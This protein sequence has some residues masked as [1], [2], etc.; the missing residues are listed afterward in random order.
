MRSVRPPPALLGESDLSLSSAQSYEWTGKVLQSLR[1]SLLEHDFLEILPAILSSQD[2]P[3][4]RH[5]VAV[6]GDRARPE[7]RARDGRVSVDG[8]WAYHLAVSH[9]VEKQMALEHAE[10][11]YCVTPCLRLLMEGEELSGKH[12][13]TFFQLVVEWRAA[14]A[15]EVFAVTESLLG[16]F[17]RHLEPVLP[18]GEG[19]GEAAARLAGLRS[20]PYPR[21]TFAEALELAGRKPHEPQNTDLT[22]DEE[23]IL[24]ENFSSPF[25]I[26]RY[27]LGV[28]D[29]LYHRAEDG[30]Q[31]T[32]DLML[33]GGHGELAT[34]GLRP[35]DEAEITEQSRLLGGEPNAAYR[36]WKE[37]S[38]IQT[39]GFGLGLERLVRHC[40]GADSVLDLLS[41]H[42]SGPNRLI[43]APQ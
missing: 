29:S 4:A 32:Y 35:R 43:G 39:A 27:P 8:K 6:L 34:G 37:R 20:G 18:T 12:L 26:H 13:Y 1:R 15:A 21:V 41:A 31:E 40:A 28:R 2:E 14:D 38:G 11:V 24:T 3:G 10:R 17:A 22:S 42:D 36:D 5:S 9:S 33:P 23:R 19:A 7:V 16:T 30:L 25:W